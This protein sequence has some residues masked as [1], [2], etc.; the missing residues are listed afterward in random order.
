[1]TIPRLLTVVS[2]LVL[3]LARPVLS[4]ANIPDTLRVAA[5]SNREIYAESDPDEAGDCVAMGELNLTFRTDSN[6][7]PSVGVV[8]TDP[9]GRRIGFDPLSEGA[10]DDLPDAQGFIDCD[11]LDNDDDSCWGIVEVC[12]PLSG[13]YKIEVIGEKASAYS[14]RVSARS[15]RTRVGNGFHDSMSEAHLKD[16]AIRRGSRDILLL[17]Y[18]RD[19]E[20]K[21]AI[22]VQSSIQAEQRRARFHQPSNG[23][24]EDPRAT[25]KLP[26]RKRTLGE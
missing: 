19:P 20:A 26:T 23:G 9:R 11:A 5:T 8:L 7:P 2:L 6:G 13:V 24:V 12:G 25:G 10:W 21:I 15:K 18:S 1:V 14:L 3:T 4:D 16:I 17:N 22:K